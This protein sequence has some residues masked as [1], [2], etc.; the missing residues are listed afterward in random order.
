MN[1][2]NIYNINMVYHAERSSHI[3]TVL[4]YS[5]GDVIHET[6]KNT[7]GGTLKP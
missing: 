7:G 1:I 2:L 3:F 4:M 5:R 6:Q